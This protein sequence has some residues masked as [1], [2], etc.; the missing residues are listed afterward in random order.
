LNH[1]M[2]WALSRLIFVIMIFISLDNGKKD[3]YS[4]GIV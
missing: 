2:I 4:R 1:L 3:K